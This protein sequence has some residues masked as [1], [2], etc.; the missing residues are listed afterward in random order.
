MYDNWDKEMV[1]H[2]RSPDAYTTQVFDLTIQRLIFAEAES[3]LKWSC[4]YYEDDSHKPTHDRVIIV[5]FHNIR[6]GT[7]IPLRGV[8]E[9]H[10]Y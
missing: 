6:G 10:G 4:W 8:I 9:L 2:E 5:C 1:G 3:F 7:H